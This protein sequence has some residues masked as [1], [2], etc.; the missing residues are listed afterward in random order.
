MRDY[1]II[2]IVLAS[3]PIGLFQPFYGLLVYAWIS[4]MYPHELAW[5]F[6]KT[7]PVAKLSVFSV[8]GGLLLH[9]SLN[10][11]ALRQREN[12]AMILLWTTFTISGFFAF[13]PDRVWA[14][15]MD[16]SKLIF[17]SLVASM[18][19]TDHTRIRQFLLVFALSLGFYGAKG[20]VFGIV[21]GGN[22]MV[23]GP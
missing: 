7:I 15:W 6:A 22:Q 17:M 11:A 8:M 23:L 16:V 5:S 4:Y 12:I 2:A 9:P 18:L 13:Y 3:L 1:L 19:L 21:T 10:I 14:S 20:G